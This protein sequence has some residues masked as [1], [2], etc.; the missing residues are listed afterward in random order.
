MTPTGLFEQTAVFEEGSAEVEA[1]ANATARSSGLGT[2]GREVFANEL[3]H[4]GSRQV[5]PEIFHGIEFRCVRGQ[6]FGG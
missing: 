4:V 5:A 3:G 6:V 1:V 2:Y